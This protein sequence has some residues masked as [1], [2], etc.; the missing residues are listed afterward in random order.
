MGFTK[1]DI[2][3]L[4]QRGKIRGYNIHPVARKGNVPVAVKSS[5]QKEWLELNL[6]M[7]CNER[8]LTLESEY[9]FVPDRKFRFDWAVPS[10]KLAIEYEGIFSAKSRHTT[11]SGFTMDQ[12]KYNRAALDGWTVIK[13]TASNYKNLLNDLKK[14]K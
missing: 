4:R 3:H 5:P 8:A 2:E 11:H 12:D 10:M 13:Y 14:V 1:K 9:R 7:W 6:Q